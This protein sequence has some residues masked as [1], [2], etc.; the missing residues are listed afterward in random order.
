MGDALVAGLCEEEDGLRAF[1]ISSAL[2]ISF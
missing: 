2:E 1:S